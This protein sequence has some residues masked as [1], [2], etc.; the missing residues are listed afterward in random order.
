MIKTAC[1]KCS[2]S[3]TMT[4][5]ICG[6]SIC[7]DCASDLT[8]ENNRDYCMP[9]SDDHFEISNGVT[10]NFSTPFETYLI[11]ENGHRIDNPV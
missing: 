2:Q 6:I 7:A 5:C 1:S 9:C 3:T 4:C 8:D 10:I 11:D